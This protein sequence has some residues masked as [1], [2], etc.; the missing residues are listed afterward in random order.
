MGF[1]TNTLCKERK[2]QMNKK[3]TKKYAVKYTL[4]PSSWFNTIDVV[5]KKEIESTYQKM[6]YQVFNLYL[7]LY[8][9]R[10]YGQDNQHIFYTSIESLRNEMQTVSMKNG[11][12]DYNRRPDAKV[13]VKYLNKLIELNI[14]TL[15]N[16]SDK[17][18]RDFLNPKTKIDSDRFLE[19]TSTVKFNIDDFNRDSTKEVNKT[20]EMTQDDY[21]IYVPFDVISSYEKY[22][23]N[24]KYYPLYCMMKKWSHTYGYTYMRQEKIAAALN[25]TRP[26][27]CKMIEEMNQKYF[28][29]TKP[30]KNKQNHIEH[31]HYVLDD[32]EDEHVNKYYLAHKKHFDKLKEAQKSQS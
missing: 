11:E 28:L 2:L 19:I 32:M 21:F 16:V 30:K 31:H 18:W 12:L 22:G 26:T 8:K 23:L 13:I 4:I 5:T 15:E 20:K 17:Q 24:E 1:F 29:V 10:I 27:V 25:I 14:I 7:Q 9:F 6:G 3:S